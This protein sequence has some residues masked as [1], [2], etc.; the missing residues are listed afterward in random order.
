MPS[1]HAGPVQVRIGRSIA[2]RSGQDVTLL[3]TGGMVQT[4]LLAADILAF[5]RVDAGVTS[6]H[7][8]KPLDE[9]AVLHAAGKGLVVTVEEHGIIGGLGSAAA[10]TLARA[11]CGHRLIACAAPDAFADT[12][13]SQAY[14]RTRA[15]LTPD[16]VA[17][18][19]LRALAS[20]G[21]V[22]AVPA[23]AE[24]RS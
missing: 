6:M 5:H 16:A 17:A 11:G 9:A 23:A 3:A 10:E 13:G 7:T 24:I 12:V 20:P 19:V 21:S 4:A 2:L 15:G 8:L 1:V 18:A 14:Y 22:P